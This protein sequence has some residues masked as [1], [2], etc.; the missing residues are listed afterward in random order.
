MDVDVSGMLTGELGLQAAGNRIWREIVEVADGKWT[1]A[2][3]LGHQEFSINRVGP[4]P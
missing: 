3:V 4:S 2:E 1:K